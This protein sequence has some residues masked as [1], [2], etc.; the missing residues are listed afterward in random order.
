MQHGSVVGAR[1][2]AAFAFAFTFMFTFT[3]A[4]VQANKQPPRY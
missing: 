4:L 3:L 1:R 2:P